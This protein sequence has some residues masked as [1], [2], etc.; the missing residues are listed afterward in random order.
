VSLGSI[1]ATS[2]LNCAFM[3]AFIGVDLAWQSAKN[4]SGL[5]TF[6]GDRSGASFKDQGV[7]VADLAGVFDFVMRNQ[8]ATTVVAIDAPL[9]VR[10]PS[11]QRPC[12]REISKRFGSAH[13]GA[14]TSNLKL[15]PNPGGVELA[16]RLTDA[17]YRHCSPPSEEWLPEGLWFFEVYPHP[18]HVVLFGRERIIKYKKGRVAA[19][20]E[21]LR[22]LRD[23][24]R[25]NLFGRGSS[26]RLG[27]EVLELLEKDLRDLHGAGLKQY[28]DTLD[29]VLCSYLAFH[30]WRWGW[31]RSE[32]IGDLESGYIVNPTVAIRRAATIVS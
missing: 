12:E 16:R 17:G 11:G 18:A 29:A 6:S 25:G 8:E 24:I 32:M 5:V 23:S 28:E 15:Y 30:L 21:G 13:A 3:S 14:H 22:E 19:R 9:I 31:S 2:D 4:H 10:N 26:L 27:P 1:T 7:G 20:R